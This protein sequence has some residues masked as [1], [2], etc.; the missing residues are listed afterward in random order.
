MLLLAT[1]VPYLTFAKNPARASMANLRAQKESKSPDAK[2][3]HIASLDKE[4]DPTAF[5][6][7]QQHKEAHE[8]FALSA[9][10]TGHHLVQANEGDSTDDEGYSEENFKAVSLKVREYLTESTADGSLAMF[11]GAV[12]LAK[13]L[14]ITPPPNS[15]IQV[16]RIVVSPAAQL[17]SSGRGQQLLEE[18]LIEQLHESFSGRSSSFSGSPELSSADESFEECCNDLLVHL[19]LMQRLQKVSVVYPREFSRTSFRHISFEAFAHTVDRIETGDLFVAQIDAYIIKELGQMIVDGRLQMNKKLPH[20]STGEHSQIVPSPDTSRDSEEFSSFMLPPPVVERDGEP[21]GLRGGSMVR[22]NQSYDRLAK[23]PTK[24]PSYQARTQSRLNKTPAGTSADTEYRR[25]HGNRRN[26]L[27]VMNS[28]TQLKNS[29]V[30]R[31]P[32]GQLNQPDGSRQ[33]GAQNAESANFEDT[34]LANEKA[35][36]QMGAGDASRSANNAPRPGRPT[37]DAEMSSPFQAVSS[38]EESSSQKQ[39]QLKTP[40]KQK[41][42]D[43]PKTRLEF[44]A[45]ISSSIGRPSVGHREPQMGVDWVPWGVRPEENRAATPPAIPLR[46]KDRESAM[47]QEPE[48][49][50]PIVHA[51]LSTN[52]QQEIVSSS[53]S[54]FLKRGAYNLSQLSSSINFP[55]SSSRCARSVA[56]SDAGSSSSVH[57]MNSMGNITYDNESSRLPANLDV[58]NTIDPPDS[59]RRFTPQTKNP[60]TNFFKSSFSNKKPKPQLIN[61]NSH[62]MADKKTISKLN[63]SRNSTGPPFSDEKAAPNPDVSKQDLSPNNCKA[64]PKMKSSFIDEPTQSTRAKQREQSQKYPSPPNTSCAKQQT[65]MP[66]LSTGQRK[67]NPRSSLGGLTGH[68][69]APPSLPT[70]AMSKVTATSSARTMDMETRAFYNML[71]PG[72]GYTPMQNSRGK[73][74]HDLQPV[75]R[76]EG[77]LRKKGMTAKGAFLKEFG[78]D[79]ESRYPHFIAAWEMVEAK[80]GKPEDDDDDELRPLPE[81]SAP[82]AKKTHTQHIVS[83]FK[84]SIS[85]TGLSN[86]AKMPSKISLPLKENLGGRS[87]SGPAAFES[88]KP[89]KLQSPSE[90][91]IENPLYPDGD[92]MCIRVAMSQVHWAGRFT[93]MNSRRM[94]DPAEFAESIALAV[95]LSKKSENGRDK[96]DYQQQWDQTWDEKEVGRAL[97]VFNELHEWCKTVEARR[98]LNEFKIHMARTTGWHV[99]L[100]A[101]VSM[102]EP[103]ASGMAKIAGKMMGKG[104][105]SIKEMQLQF[106]E[107]R[108]ADRVTA[109][110]TKKQPFKPRRSVLGMNENGIPGY[111]CGIP[112]MVQPSY[113]GSQIPILKG[114]RRASPRVHTPTPNYAISSPVQRVESKNSGKEPSSGS[115]VGRTWYGRKKP[116]PADDDTPRPMAKAA[117]KAAVK[118]NAKPPPPKPLTKEEKKREK[119]QEQARKNFDE[120]LTWQ[121]YGDEAPV[122]PPVGVWRSHQQ[123]EVFGP[124]ARRR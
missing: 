28:Y 96:E 35:A 30:G 107:K 67:Y 77:Y 65:V 20:V 11:P 73:M 13:Y 113:Q 5:V 82:V 23:S 93:S 102:K 14:G 57:H 75:A 120:R 84:K 70:V 90:I 104:D 105:M 72:G 91:F 32:L 53:G 22:P 64:Q 103:P 47:N 79:Y 40:L 88:L 101:G 81:L 46:S 44:K 69:R 68:L 3:P 95:K 116:A 100:P 18:Q 78:G 15:P 43:T 9:S 48:L 27:K 51:D 34:D 108:E 61:E 4:Y 74:F 39:A 123:E 42:T 59:A 63:N 26:K 58:A 21:V 62:S 29:P 124:D 8:N 25:F 55:G 31:Q 80:Y 111:E 98:S 109:T 38:D 119:A 36:L 89:S 45:E 17:P 106:R 10:P 122:R 1:I 2:L 66:Q 86:L 118:E 54:N 97:N 94:N 16:S 117:A 71:W 12:A 33:G 121:Q 41:L 92:C 49:S 83:G 85:K 24:K 87:T 6:T 56:S 19:K 112:A 37:P 7:A 110:L 60:N 76:N 52:R 99:L 114:A 50:A 115:T